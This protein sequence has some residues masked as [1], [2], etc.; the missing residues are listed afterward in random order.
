MNLSKIFTTIILAIVLVFCNACKKE[1]FTKKFKKEC[2]THAATIDS[3]GSAKF[4]IPNSFTPNQDGINDI[5]M[6]FTDQEII[7]INSFRIVNASGLLVFE[8]VEF[9]GNDPSFGWDGHLYDQTINDGIFDYFVELENINN[10]I[11]TV[12][13][14]VSCRTSLPIPCVDHEA[15]CIFGTQHDGNGG[16]DDNLP[17]YE[18][19]E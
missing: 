5:F 9:L 10:E 17:S 3:V 16:Y 1:G 6:I 12:S 13:G 15:S 18:E 19:C 14:K 8:L 11:K 7:K 4:F 2:C